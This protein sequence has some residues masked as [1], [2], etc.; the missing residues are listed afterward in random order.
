MP[1]VAASVGSALPAVLD[2]IR[3]LGSLGK[4]LHFHLHD[5]HPLS[6]FSPFGVSDHLS[7]LAEIPL[8]FEYRGRRSAPLMFGPDGLAQIVKQ[9][10]E[11]VPPA[12]VS[13]TFE[14]HPTFE[15]RPLDDA[16]QLFAHWSD[17]ANAERMNHWL[18]TIA[19][20]QRLIAPPAGGSGR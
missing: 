1:D 16:A 7:F 9:A 8:P 13:F 17:K 5:G 11:R 4:P 18:W 2:L 15:R 3:V 12:P 19:S 14:I 6:T 20:N 10:V